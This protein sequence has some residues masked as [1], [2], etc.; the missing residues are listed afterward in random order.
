M[1]E[2]LIIIGAGG[3]GRNVAEIVQDN[4][5]PW[6]LIG[7]LD[8]DPGKQET[9]VNGVPV[10]GTTSDIHRYEDCHFVVLI[11]N[12]KERFAKKRLVDRLAIRPEQLATIIHPTAI[13]SRY[14]EVG[15]G[16]VIYPMVTIM[17][18]A[19]IGDHVFIASKSNIGHNT[20][21][22]D[23]VFI[24]ALAGIAGN[25]VIEEGAFIGLNASVRDGVTVGKWASVGMGSAVVSD[26][27]PYHVVTGNPARVLRRLDPADFAE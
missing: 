27:Q 13:I 2:K 5:L 14:A 3:D 8:D 6:T 23:H 21:I 18:N 25:A 1:T 7:F 17:A 19:K 24:T 11:G 4:S 10:L 20:T 16:T 26:V 9:E 12:P 22:G 15:R